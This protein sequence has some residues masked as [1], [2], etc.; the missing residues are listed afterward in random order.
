MSLQTESGL[1]AHMHEADI[2]PQQKW[3][4][5]FPCRP[6]SLHLLQFTR[7][8][9]SNPTSWRVRWRV[10]RLIANSPFGVSWI[11]IF[12]TTQRLCWVAAAE[13]QGY[14]ETQSENT[15]ASQKKIP[16]Y[17]ENVYREWMSTD[18]QTHQ[19]QWRW[20]ALNQVL[21][22]VFTPNPVYPTLLLS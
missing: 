2:L 13:K 6:P 8:C 7:S 15:S 11:G 16:P 10:L 18:R 19:K 4:S 5:S 20:K 17:S 14:N 3:R 12:G 22:A 21:T 1:L 9:R